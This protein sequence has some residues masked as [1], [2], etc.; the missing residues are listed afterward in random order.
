MGAVHFG[1]T[2]PVFG[3]QTEACRAAQSLS[4]ALSPCH[5]RMGPACQRI[6]PTRTLC[7][8]LPDCGPGGSATHHA[9]HAIRSSSPSPTA[10]PLPTRA[11]GGTAPRSSGRSGSVARLSLL[12]STEAQRDPPQWSESCGWEL[13]PWPELPDLRGEHPPARTLP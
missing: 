3:P 13:T 1:P 6:P 8:F 9:Q 10:S 4:R 2:N 12:R 5:R 7:R 11:G